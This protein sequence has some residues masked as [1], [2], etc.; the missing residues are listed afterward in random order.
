MV[1]R[2]GQLRS[3]LSDDRFYKSPVNKG[4]I[5]LE[6]KQLELSKGL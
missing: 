5:M 2:E 4:R 6:L 1:A 3:K